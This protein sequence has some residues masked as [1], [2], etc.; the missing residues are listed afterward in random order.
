MNTITNFITFIKTLYGYQPNKL[1][2]IL[3]N[4]DGIK[5]KLK[6]FFYMEKL[7]SYDTRCDDAWF[8]KYVL[9][10]YGHRYE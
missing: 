7:I 9:E 2:D 5:L 8:S 1:D 4:Y 6:L 10:K 3:A